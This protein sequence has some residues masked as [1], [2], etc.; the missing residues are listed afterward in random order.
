M[1]IDKEVTYYKSRRKR[2]IYLKLIVYIFLIALSSVF[3]FPL[4]WMISTSLKPETQVFVFPPQLIPRPVIWKNYIKVLPLMRFRITLLNTL[5][6]V[7][8]NVAGSLFSSSLVAYSFARLRWPGRDLFFVILLSTMMIPYIVTMIPIF[9]VFNRLGWVN[10]FKPLIVPSFFGSPFYI[11]LARQFFRTIPN[12]LSDAAKIDGCSEF[13]IYLNIILPLCKPI[14]AVI[15][16][17]SFMGAWNDFLGPLI[18]LNN[19]DKW[20]LSLMLY[21]MRSAQ[22]WQLSWPLLMAGSTI[23]TLP[24]IIIF[25]FTQKTFIQSITLT[26]I[27]G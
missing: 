3:A 13:G 26:G 4:F 15:G 14:L 17:F 1:R 19:E 20:P 5:L 18:Y 12:D 11:F 21:A 27:K 8:G 7:A 24:V 23:M 22:A 16:I 25:F 6:I 2:E 10:T 9:V